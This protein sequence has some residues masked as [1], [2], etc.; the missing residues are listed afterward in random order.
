MLPRENDSE[1]YRSETTLETQPLT[2]SAHPK[3]LWH[4]PT[5]RVLGGDATAGGGPVVPT[6]DA[7]PTVGPGS[8]P[9]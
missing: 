4:P 9:S 8:A 5:W 3:R 2:A 7:T 6:E 1:L